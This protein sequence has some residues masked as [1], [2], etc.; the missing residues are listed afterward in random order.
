METLR[1]QKWTTRIKHGLTRKPLGAIALALALL[2]LPAQA[3]MLIFDYDFN[4][5]GGGP[6][7]SP[8]RPRFGRGVIVPHHNPA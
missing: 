6:Q 7:P 4:F 2:P 3:T 1:S 5:T 8:P